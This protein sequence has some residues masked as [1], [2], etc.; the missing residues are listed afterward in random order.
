MDG[1]AA[2]NLDL[3]PDSLLLGAFPERFNA[4]VEFD[5]ALR[6]LDVGS[7]LSASQAA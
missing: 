5:L 4:S 3:P 2:L 6:V 7:S 1:L